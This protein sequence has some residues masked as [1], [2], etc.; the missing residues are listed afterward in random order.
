MAVSGPRR[1]ARRRAPERDLPGAVVALDNAHR[2]RTCFVQLTADVEYRARAG[3]ASSPTLVET[4][5]PRSRPGAARLLDGRDPRPI[6][7]NYRVIRFCPPRELRV[8]L[9][10]LCLEL[11][12]GHRRARHHAFFLSV[13]GG[14]PPIYAGADAARRGSR[15]SPPAPIAQRVADAAFRR[16]DMP[17]DDGGRGRPIRGHKRVITQ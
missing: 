3:D 15:S 1:F 5:P 9:G 14:A 10:E 16:V 12:A 4:P 17:D 8:E 7:K 6:D 11:F 2:V 13:I